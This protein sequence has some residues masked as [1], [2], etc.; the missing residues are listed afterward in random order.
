MIRSNNGDYTHKYGNE[1]HQNGQRWY[2]VSSMAD[3]KAIVSRYL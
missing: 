1:Y 2:G 3:A